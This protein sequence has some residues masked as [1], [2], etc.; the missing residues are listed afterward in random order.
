M[1][2]IEDKERDLIISSDIDQTSV[3]TIIEQ[4]IYINGYDDKQENEKKEYVRKPIRLI[5]DTYGGS[6]YSGFALIAAIEKSKTPVHTIC[7]GK[8]MSMG[9]V[10]MLAGHKRF[11]HPLGTVMYHQIATGVWDKIEGIKQEL[12]Q[13]ERLEKLG[14]GFILSHTKIRQKELDEVK[15]LK[16]EWYIGADEALKLGIIDEIL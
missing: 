14:E 11:M 2:Y 1:A 5:V 16:K 9:F 3:K 10:I 8:A 4:I 13:V 7:L 15:K 12:E 6:V